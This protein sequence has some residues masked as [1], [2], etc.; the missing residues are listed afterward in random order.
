MTSIDYFAFGMAFSLDR[1]ANWRP[2]ARPVMVGLLVIEVTLMLYTGRVALRQVDYQG[3]LEQYRAFSH[4]V[5]PHAIV[6]F[7][8]NQPVGTAGIIGTPLA[9]LDG[10]TV[11]DLQEDSLNRDRLDEL[12]QGWFISGRTVVVVDGPARVSGLCDR[13]QCQS[14]GTV[15]F[16]LPVLEASYEHFPVRIDRLQFP[17][18]I[19]EVKSLER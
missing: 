3:G 14:L 5:P 13:W 11:I 7:N 9:Y 16:N 19:Y 2:I 10:H 8:D 17:L 4:Y 12:V 18:N 1:L 15:Q 6:L